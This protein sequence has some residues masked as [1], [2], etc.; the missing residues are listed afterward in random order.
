MARLYDARNIA[1]GST[2]LLLSGARLYTFD[3][4]S[5]TTPKATYADNG[6]TVSNGAYVEADSSGVFPPIYG[7]ANE[8]YYCVLKDSAGNT[9]D[10]IPDVAM[11]GPDSSS[12][13]LKDLGVN[14]RFLVSGSGGVVNIETGNAIGDDI[15]GTAR[16]GGYAGTQG[17]ALE[18]DY[19][20]VTTTGPVS[21]AGSVTSSGALISTSGAV[22]LQGITQAVPRALVRS[23]ATA[24]A[25]TDITLDS[26]YEEWEIR[27]R[28]MVVN[29]T[30]AARFS[31]DGA[32][33]KSG[34][35]DYAWGGGYQG[36][37]S[38]TNTPWATGAQIL[39][40]PGTSSAGKGDLVIRITSKAARETR[41]KC[42]FLNYSS[43]TAADQ[44]SGWRAGST[45]DKN[46]GKVASIRIF[47]TTAANLT[48]D[49]VVIGMP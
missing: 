39:L 22:T 8:Q 32:T 37:A 49:Y 4:V 9:I 45:N 27:I 24:A 43:G 2:G 31:F 47:E 42:D 29:G 35:A 46:Y 17:D 26:A 15:G 44:V 3:S 34:A 1:W 18:L 40:M 33:F 19:A 10:E 7:A 30:L 14:G 48:F 20:A 16:I 13:F 41:L 23:S 12:T 38:F 21:V 36:S 6:L 11:L 25:N 28:N 5:T